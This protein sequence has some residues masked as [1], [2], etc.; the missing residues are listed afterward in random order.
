[1]WA[2]KAINF[3]IIFLKGSGIAPEMEALR[4]LHQNISPMERRKPV[5]LLSVERRMKQW[6]NRYFFLDLL[7]TWKLLL[8]NRVEDE[9]FRKG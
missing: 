1:M 2:N 8:Q 5:D 4:H 3:K 7:T 9:G 6:N